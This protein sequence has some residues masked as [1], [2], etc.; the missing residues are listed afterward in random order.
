MNMNE[1]SLQW[2]EARVREE[3]SKQD[4]KQIDT[5]AHETSLA[6]SNGVTSRPGSNNQKSGQP[7]TKRKI[8]GYA[9]SSC[10]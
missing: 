5:S 4:L 7:K 8:A 3:I 10:F 6:K 9:G 1:T 2:R